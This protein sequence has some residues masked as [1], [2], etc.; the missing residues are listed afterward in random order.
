M[1]RVT[2]T[3]RRGHGIPAAADNLHRKPRSAGVLRFPPGAEGEGEGAGGLDC[4]VGAN[5]VDPGV[6]Y[7]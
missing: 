3:R 2:Q 7:F 5:G 6:C 4:M 1:E